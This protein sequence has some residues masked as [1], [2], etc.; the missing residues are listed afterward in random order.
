MSAEIPDPSQQVSSNWIKSP[1]GRRDLFFITV[2]VAPNLLIP[3]L[4]VDLYPFSRAPMFS[5]APKVYCD[6]HLFDPNGNEF[7][8]L[9]FGLQRNYWGNP[10]GEGV[11]FLPPATVDQFGTVA[12]TE[13][14]SAHLRRLLLRKPGLAY[15]NVVQEVIG[16][17]D[18][19][20]VGVIRTVSWRVDNPAYQGRE[21]Q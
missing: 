4:I 12:T 17:M 7:R 6:Y 13:D 21:G 20:R 10:V 9:D 14:V 15:V 16:D 18:G 3:L 1:H 11:G 2:F 5:D 19:Q 8:P